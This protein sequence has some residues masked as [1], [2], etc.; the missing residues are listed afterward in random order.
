[1]PSARE[2]HGRGE[3]EPDQAGAGLVA[4]QPLALAQ[5]LCGERDD[6][7]LGGKAA[8]FEAEGPEVIGEGAD[9]RLDEQV[10]RGLVVRGVRNG[11]ALGALQVRHGAGCMLRRIDGWTGHAV[12]LC[13]NSGVCA[14]GRRRG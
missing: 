1:M 12:L 7:R 9:V 10:E 11:F 8:G 3:I 4:Q 6:R 14:P 5:Q 13:G 2:Q